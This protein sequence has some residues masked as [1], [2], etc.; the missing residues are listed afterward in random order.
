MKSWN[1]TQK[2][3]LAVA[4]A[5]LVTTG[6]SQAW[7]IAQ[8]T[9]GE[10]K[11]HTTL[12]KTIS[13]HQAA[14]TKALVAC[15]IAELGGGPACPDSDALAAIQKSEG[16]T[17]ASATKSC[18][19]ICNVSE[20]PCIAS[21]TCPPNGSNLESCTA[22]PGKSFDIATMGFPGPYCDVF[23]SAGYL[24]DP[25][26]FGACAVGIG[27]NIA[28]EIIDNLIGDLVAAP[29]GEALDCL[30]ALAKA[31]PKS[32]SK[33]AGAVSKCRASQLTAD[34][35]SILPSDCATA[36]VK[37][38]DS[39]QKTRDKFSE[40]ITNSC[41]A[42][43]LTGLS[44]CG[45]PVGGVTSVMQATTCLLGV[46]DE[47]SI[48]ADNERA[49]A[50]VSIINGAYPQTAAA[51]CGDN[52]INQL[53]NAFAFNGEE[54]DGTSL[55]DCA[56]CLPPDDVFECTCAETRRA[57]VFAKGFQADLDNGWTG[58]SHNNKTPD[59]AGFVSEVSDCDCTDFTGAACTGTSGD[60]ECTI[61]AETQPR[62]SHRIGDG[63]SCDEVGNGN[64][65]HTDSDC[66]A[67]SVEA[68][69][70]GDFCTG[71]ARFCLG[72][73]SNG[74]RCNSTDDCTG[75]GTCG[76]TGRC[77]EGP[78][79]GNGCT[80]A[81]QCGICTAGTNIGQPCST[82]GH[83]GVGGVCEV[84]NSCV[85]RSCLGG[86]NDE[87]A[88]NTNAECGGGGTC[89]ETSDC[90][91]RCYDADDNDMG[92]CWAQSDCAAGER[93]RGA[94]DL[95]NSCIVSQNSAPLPLSSEGTSVCV[96]SGFF[97]N[98][99]GTR[100][101]VSGAHAVDYELRSL[102]HFGGDNMPNSVPCPVCG[103]YCAVNTPPTA[104]DRV[105][106]F[107]TCSGPEL[108]CRYGEN[109]GDT[110]MTNA[111]CL[112]FL[113]DQVACRFDDECPSGTC[114]GAASPDCQGDECRLDLSCST[115]PNEGSPCRI[116]AYTAFGTTSAD[117][118]PWP[119][120]NQ[121]GTG[122]A[123][124]WTPLTSGTV[125]LESPATCNAAG[126][127]N[128][129]CNCVFGGGV[130]NAPNKCAPACTN[131]TNPDDI[132]RS[133]VA[134]TKCVGGSEP[135]VA[136]DTNADCSGGGTCTNNPRVCGTGNAGVCSLSHCVGGESNGGIC[137]SNSQC[138]TSEGVIDGVCTSDPCTV[139]GA[140]CTDGECIPDNCSTN[141][142]CEMGVTCDDVCPGGLCTPLCIERGV[143][144]G[145]ERDGG[146]CA[147][148]KDCTGGGTCTSPNSEEGAC[149]Q[150]TFNHCDGPG[151]EFVSC[152][153]LQV[154]T[155]NGCEWGTDGFEGGPNANVGAGYCRA[156]INHC[157]INNGEATGGG[158]PTEPFSVAGF[159]IP[160]SSSPPI[161]S[162]AGLP[163]PGRIRQP[164]TVVINFDSLP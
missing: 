153:P 95:T 155:K 24:R 33:M 161:N 101:I 81:Q 88:C 53:P 148:D 100:D 31:M 108:E 19:S 22:G 77:Y 72:G 75:G 116:E 3:W 11:C 69:N 43:G 86:A 162:T 67:C 152:A 128:F 131:P 20:V 149:A 8:N 27:E 30:E 39:L 115:G 160:A 12:N 25:E 37:T 120:A 16:K 102:V 64:N 42:M 5:L 141:G 139:G 151:W 136:C 38:A 105:R 78:F 60:S 74:A 143:C 94:C 71:D 47:V 40:T 9:K 92:P 45:E 146:Y 2:A 103:A 80:S 10:G 89:S 144:S 49:Y 46:L 99:T 62:C 6:A 54:C 35:P 113:C 132:G 123:I 126:F 111:D 87:D 59:G 147:L 133:C 70:A 41:T 145:G 36:D 85:P 127:Q 90:F 164:S 121:T 48:S 52:L 135:N 82:A 96:L 140:P 66:R 119:T 50:P 73:T 98:V 58:A 26:D 34:S 137:A 118:P 44:L 110:C 1:R 76:A 129:M 15:K 122:L 117:C 163:G 114:S 17:S 159:C 142:D 65:V 61:F 84:H 130:T 134:F 4:T 112:G 29:T 104:H 28:N 150:G 158:T 125:T 56:A 157:F 14:V 156:D 18:Q 138:T 51:R 57:R 91:S 13:K 124:S 79:V 109:K 21:S 154:N 83:C 97:S 23:S 93:C 7:A 32:A 55:G 106:C 63:T 107:G 68:T